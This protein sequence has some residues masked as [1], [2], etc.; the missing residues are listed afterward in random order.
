MA[1][2]GSTC[3]IALALKDHGLKGFYVKSYCLSDRKKTGADLIALPRAA[4][5]FIKRFDMEIKTKPFEFDIDIPE[6]PRTEVVCPVEKAPHPLIVELVKKI[7]REPKH[8]QVEVA[9]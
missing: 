6:H 9:K 5:T 2:D 4:Q 1:G 7:N 8:I 3:P